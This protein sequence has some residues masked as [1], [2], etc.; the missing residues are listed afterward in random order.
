[1]TAAASPFAA[2]G[3]VGR[4]LPQAGHFLAAVSTDFP[5]PVQGFR[6]KARP[7]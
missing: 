7:S 1:M 4:N 5:Q 6:A 3:V 2:F